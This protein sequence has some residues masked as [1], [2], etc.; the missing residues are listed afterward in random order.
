MIQIPETRDLFYPETEVTVPY[1]DGTA[2]R[3]GKDLEAE[4]LVVDGG[5]VV[6]RHGEREFPINSSVEQYRDSLAL[7]AEVRDGFAAGAIEDDDSAVDA[8]EEKLRS[9]DALAYDAPNS[10]WAAIVEQIRLE[11]F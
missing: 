3:I 8:L 2:S 1:G 7:V 5:G 10:Y 4:I 6:A 9:L 11:Q